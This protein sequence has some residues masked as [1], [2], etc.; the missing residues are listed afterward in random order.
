MFTCN[1]ILPNVNRKK[2]QAIIRRSMPFPRETPRGFELLK[3]GAEFDV[4]CPS[5]ITYLPIFSIP[6]LETGS[7]TLNQIFYTF[8]R[9]H[10]K[11]VETLFGKP[12]DRSDIFAF[13]L[14][15]GSGTMCILPDKMTLP[16]PTPVKFKCPTPGHG[17]WSNGCGMPKKREGGGGGARWRFE[18]IG[19]LPILTLLSRICEQTFV[20][21]VHYCTSL[22]WIL[23][24]LSQSNM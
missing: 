16:H 22:G 9:K 11:F 8:L 14:D 3:I 15:P 6:Y 5:P 24:K 10:C 18:L 2:L 23:R 20:E 17:K 7:F 12:I 19:A 13:E 21:P 4:K 1:S